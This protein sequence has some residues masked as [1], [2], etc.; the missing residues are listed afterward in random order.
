MFYNDPNEINCGNTPGNCYCCCDRG[1][2]GPQGPMGPRGCPGPQ[3]STGVTGP[4]G[5]TGATGA[6]G[7]AG[8][9]GPTGATGATGPTGASGPAGPTGATGST[10]PTGPTGASGVSAAM[11]AL[12][13]SAS[14]FS[15]TTDGTDISL[16]VQ[17]Y[18]NGFTANA[19]N[20]AFTVTQT[21]TY[22]ISYDIKMTS[23][24]PMSSRVTLNGTPI[25]NSVSTSSSASNEYSVTFMQALTA[26]DIIS[27]QLY[28]VNGQVTLQ[29]GT[30]ASLNIV[31]IS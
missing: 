19:A 5:A 11:S 17:P 22:L 8:P 31:K 18:M 3:G 14:T 21:G 25:L 28:G 10:G 23:G 6:S 30:G 12:N 2:I 20:T 1:P 16:P 24:L 26:G 7:P 27:L 9:T 4:T 13:T 15:V 29:A